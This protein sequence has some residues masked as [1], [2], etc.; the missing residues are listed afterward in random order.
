MTLNKWLKKQISYA[1]HRLS[2]E[3]VDTPEYDRW[4]D[5]L[6]FLEGQREWLIEWSGE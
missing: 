2:R 4:W 5:I 3:V 6:E 1:E